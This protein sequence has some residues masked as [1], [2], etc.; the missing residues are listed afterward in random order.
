MKELILPEFL[1]ASV[2]QPLG[3]PNPLEKTRVPGGV[4]IAIPD[5]V[6]D[7]YDTILT[8]TPSAGR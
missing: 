2:V 4:K 5:E 7:P 6:R 8:A 3:K 1:A